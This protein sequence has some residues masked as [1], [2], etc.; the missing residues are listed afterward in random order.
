MIQTDRRNPAKIGG[1][2]KTIQTDEQ[3]DASLQKLV[4]RIQHYKQQT[5]RHNLSKIGGEDKMLQTDKQTDAIV[6]GSQL[7]SKNVT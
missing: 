2:D 5:E 3:R 6:K 7:W 1:E 4:V